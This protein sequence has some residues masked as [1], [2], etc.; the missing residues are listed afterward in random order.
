[1]PQLLHRCPGLGEA[2]S[3]GGG[4]RP[5]DMP[6]HE[7]RVSSYKGYVPGQPASGMTWRLFG[8]EVLTRSWFMKGMS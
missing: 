6:A 5:G 8:G 4:Q 7:R 1:M 2:V 3:I